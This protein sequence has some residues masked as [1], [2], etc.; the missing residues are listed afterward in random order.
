MTLEQCSIAGGKGQRQD[1]PPSLLLGGTIVRR[2]LHSLSE[3]GRD[4]RREQRH[5][6]SAK[7]NAALTIKV[8]PECQHLK[9]GCLL[10]RGTLSASSESWPRLEGP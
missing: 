9:R 4:R 8:V 1:T 10:K 7:L 5:L 3:Q 2:V 6:P